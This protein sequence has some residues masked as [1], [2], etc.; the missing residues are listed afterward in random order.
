VSGPRR[1]I[2]LEDERGHKTITVN[3]AYGLSVKW[4][5]HP[6]GGTVFYIDRETEQS[7]GAQ[8]ASTA[9]RWSGT[10][11]DANQTP[12]QAQVQTRP[13]DN[14]PTQMPEATIKR[15]RGRPR[16][17]PIIEPMPASFAEFKEGLEPIRK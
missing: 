17:R 7:S 12:T 11:G 5:V 1:V 2:S 3:M 16:T 14:G 9:T 13:T 4:A 8:A 6:D 15:R 10:V